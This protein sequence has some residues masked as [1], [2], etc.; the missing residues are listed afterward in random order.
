VRD[1]QAQR[2]EGVR[3]PALY[4]RG[5]DAGGV[6]HPVRRLDQNGEQDVVL[7]IVEMAPL[8]PL[9]HSGT[10]GIDPGGVLGSEIAPAV[11]RT[12]RGPRG[13]V[14]VDESGRGF[15]MVQVIDRG[16]QS[17]CRAADLG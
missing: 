10:Y 16:P 5:I 3:L 17:I 11:H 8:S 15:E 14:F 12:A 1:P 6:R 13:E 7:V 4:I 2:L 9:V